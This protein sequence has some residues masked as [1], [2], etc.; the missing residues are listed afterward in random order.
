M[1]ELIAGGEGIAVL[2]LIVSPDRGA[3]FH[4][5]DRHPRHWKLEPGDVVGGGESGVGLRL[6]A[7]LYAEA[8]IVRAILPNRRRL[9]ANSAG[10]QHGHRQAL[11][12]DV[13]QFGGVAS[14]ATAVRHHEGDGIAD[15]GH[16]VVGQRGARWL[17]HRRAIRSFQRHRLGGEARHVAEPGGGDIGAGIDRQDPG[18]RACRGNVDHTDSCMGMGRAQDI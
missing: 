14:L 1:R 2:E 9:G 10:C 18:R 4:R 12:V 11:I 8:D 6:I 17:E 5:I 7:Q 15:E 16:L 3:R 13:D